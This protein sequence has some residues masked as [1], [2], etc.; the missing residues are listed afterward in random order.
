MPS[1]AI[2]P[3][4]LAIPR[5]SNRSISSCRAF[6]GLNLFRPLSIAPSLTA[7]GDPAS[8]ATI[9]MGGGPRTYPGGV[10]K[11][12]WKRMQAKKSKQLLKARL[13]RERQLYEMRKRAELKAAISELERPW[14]VVE[15]APVLFSASADE[16]VKALADRFQRPNGFDMWSDRDG[17]RL[18]RSP[19]DLPSARFFPKDAVHSVKPYGVVADEV[20]DG[21]DEREKVR[22]YDDCIARGAG[23]MGTRRH[24]RVSP[25][26]SSLE[27]ERSVPVEEENGDAEGHLGSYYSD[28]EF[29]VA[30]SRKAENKMI[31]RF[32]RHGRIRNSPGAESNLALDGSSMNGGDKSGDFGRRSSRGRNWSSRVSDSKQAEADSRMEKHEIAGSFGRRG[33]R[34]V[35][36]RYRNSYGSHKEFAVNGSRMGRDETASDFGQRGSGDRNQGSY[37]SHSELAV[38][39]SRMQRHE[40][41]GGFDR[42]R[43]R[44]GRGGNR[45]SYQSYSGLEK[46]ENDGGFEKRGGRSGNRNGVFG[47]RGGRG[48]NR[49]S[50]RSYSDLAITGS[51]ME[52]DEIA[53]GFGKRGGRSGNRNFYGS[54]SELAIADSWK[55][56]V[57][58]AG[59]RDRDYS[60]RGR[61]SLRPTT[62]L[63]LE[64]GGHVRREKKSEG[65]TGDIRVSREIKSPQ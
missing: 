30:G 50:N 49:G 39:S 11:W 35:R 34:G 54:D 57:E 36:G 31:R 28:S 40:M 33:G 55:E 27:S 7:A 20:A 52:K 60:Y 23:G 46:D 14:E 38:A 59:G 13:C 8:L 51:R 19:D 62:E 37:E 43:G 63:R 15:R 58:M 12:Q 6:T 10:S 5:A 61:V 21:G 48:G 65:R 4:S 56:R 16:Q 22:R 29:A 17:P 45:G 2:I 3:A 42:R 44:G 1:A 41:A 64:E 47:R 18:F 26:S 32:A 53:G 9:R 25:D 24:V